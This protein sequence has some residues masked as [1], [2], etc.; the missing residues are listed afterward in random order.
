M[1]LT[2]IQPMSDGTYRIKELDV[3]QAFIT[4]DETDEVFT[5]IEIAQAELTARRLRRVYDNT[6]GEIWV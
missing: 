1:K 4:V 2:L 6:D 5:H 3:L